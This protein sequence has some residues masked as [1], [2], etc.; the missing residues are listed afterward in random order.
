MLE[1]N[2][3]LPTTPA[4]FAY[5][6]KLAVY[7]KILLEKQLYIKLLTSLIGDVIFSGYFKLLG[8]LIRSIL[9]TDVWSEVPN[10]AVEYMFYQ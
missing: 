4:P 2:K 6:S 8:P 1:F 5:S 3:G 9:G 10:C 7:F